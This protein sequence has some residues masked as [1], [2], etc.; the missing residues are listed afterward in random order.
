MLKSKLKRFQNDFIRKKATLEWHRTNLETCTKEVT[1]AIHRQYCN[2]Q[3]WP[4]EAYLRQISELEN[5]INAERGKY[6]LEENRLKQLP[7]IDQ[8]VAELLSNLTHSTNF[9][10]QSNEVLQE[11]IKL[12]PTLP[13]FPVN[14]PT[15][16][17]PSDQFMRFSDEFV[18][19]TKSLFGYCTFESTFQMD[20]QI[21][22]RKVTRSKSL[23]EIPAFVKLPQEPA[24]G[25]F[26][27]GSSSLSSIPWSFRQKPSAERKEITTLEQSIYEVCFAY[28]SKTIQSH[29]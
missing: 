8:L 2:V 22:P 21:S 3:K 1:E 15:F 20:S 10:Q 23:D 16:V 29:L 14:G 19:L 5:V 26:S 12:G 17:E 13:E 18:N 6:L 27:Q 7:N 28:N 4:R 9:I 25:L 11:Q 24:S